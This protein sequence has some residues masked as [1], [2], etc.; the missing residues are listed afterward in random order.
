[1]F[2][3]LSGALTQFGAACSNAGNGIKIFPTWY[4]YLDVKVDVSGRCAIDLDK[5]PFPEN[6]PLVALGVVDILL[7]LAAFVALGYLIYGGIMYI[8]SQGEPDKLSGARQAVTNA[9]IGLVIAIF[10]T[11]IVT[12]VG[13]QLT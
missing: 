5:S 8:T 11:V 6:I 4:Q 9:I 2:G 10:A 13:N 12:F 1:M 7:R 3:L